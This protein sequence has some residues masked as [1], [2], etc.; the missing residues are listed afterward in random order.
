MYMYAWFTSD[1]CTPVALPIVWSA[2]DV[3]ALARPIHVQR[4]S[5]T[6]YGKVRTCVVY[7]VTCNKCYYMYIIIRDHRLQLWTQSMHNWF[8]FTQSTSTCTSNVPVSA[9]QCQLVPVGASWWAHRHGTSP[10]VCNT[11]ANREPRALLCT[12]YEGTESRG[13]DGWQNN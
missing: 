4:W 5:E 13:W 3:Y 6:G 11:A 1:A 10:L 2:V 7:P 8:T 12:M 9:C